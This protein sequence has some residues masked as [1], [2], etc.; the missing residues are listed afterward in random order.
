MPKYGSGVEIGATATSGA[1]SLGLQEQAVF[2]TSPVAIPACTVNTH[3]LY[4]SD[5][6]QDGLLYDL[7]AK[8]GSLTTLRTSAECPI[9][10]TCLSY[11]RA[12]LVGPTTCRNGFIFSVEDHRMGSY[13]ARQPLLN[14]PKGMRL[15]RA[16][17]WRRLTIGK[18]RSATG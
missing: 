3:Y 1:S 18:M 13:S 12:M 15:A 11:F 5:G 6:P 16:Y 17:H 14:F 10:P 7:E 8:K 2:W 4:F 9:K